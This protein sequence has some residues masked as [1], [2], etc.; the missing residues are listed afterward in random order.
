MSNVM[1]RLGVCSWSLQP[2]SPR[3]LADKVA[4]LGLRKVQLHLDPIREGAWKADET[5]GLLR[6]ANVRIA[7]GMMGTKGEDYSTLES[8]RLTGGLR[9]DEHWEANLKAAEGNAIFAARFGIPLVT[10]H[11]GFLPHDASD[12]LRTRMVERLRQFAEV[13]AARN[14]RVALETGQEDA[15]TLLS[16]LSDVN[17]ELAP[18]ARLGVNFDPANM[19]LYAMGD[20]ID[21]L[22]RL[23]PHVMQ[24]HIKDAK[25]TAKPGTWGSEEVAGTG[26]V[27]W[28]RFFEAVHAARLQCDLMIER[29]AGSQRESDIRTARDLVRRVLG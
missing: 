17:T 19:I 11:A 8:I 29:E 28:P 1:D 3:E 23:A 18:R 2:A 6:L 9:P 24:I 5:A 26:A 16:V 7:S 14:V 10:F 25:P 21:A 27:D 4:S 12:P 15:T 13:F 20:P 22:Q